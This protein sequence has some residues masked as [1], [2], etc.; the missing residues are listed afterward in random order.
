[1]RVRVVLA[2]VCLLALCRVSSAQDIPHAA[3]RI[4]FGQEWKDWTRPIRL[5]YLSAY[6]DGESDT[7]QKAVF[8]LPAAKRE[9]FRLATALFFDVGAIADVMTDLYKD[10][11]N[12]FVRTGAMVY[13]A[14]DKLSGK[15]V[16]AMLRYSR[17]H[18][19]AFPK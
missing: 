9:P 16:E 17:E 2:I 19:Y 13:I 3:D 12:T 15:D 1:M 7:Y 10:P 6:M 18:D 4:N 8:D 14:R 11:A 5:I